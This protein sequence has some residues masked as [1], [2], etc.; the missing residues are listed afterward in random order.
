MLEWIEKDLKAQ[1]QKVQVSVKLGQPPEN[2]SSVPFLL[3]LNR[4]AAVLDPAQCIST[5][6]IETFLL[7]KMEFNREGHNVKFNT[8]ASAQRARSAATEENPVD[9]PEGHNPLDLDAWVSV[10]TLSARTIKGREFVWLK[11][12]IK[13]FPPLLVTNND[14]NNATVDQDKLFT[15]LKEGLQ[16]LVT[17]TP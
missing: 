17:V 6:R 8:C 4:Y 1:L 14:F 5:K 13:T 2:H 15:F 12:E 10:G 16:P 11:R 9:E 7:W 3:A